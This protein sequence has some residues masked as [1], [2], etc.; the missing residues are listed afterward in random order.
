MSVRKPQIFVS[1]SQYDRDIRASFNTIFART[2]V[3]S[4]CIEFEKVSLPAWPKIKDAINA[5]ETVF[6]LLGPKIRKSIY[7]Q[8]WIAFEVGLSCALGK[9]VWV[10]EQM[11]SKIDFPIP[12]V[13]DYLLYSLD[14][15]IHFDY[16]KGI[17]EGY[18]ENVNSLHPKG[19]IPDGLLVEC[20]HCH[21]EF[22][23]HQTFGA[24]YCPSCRKPSWCK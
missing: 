24:Y 12:Y 21:L 2:N 11:G 4:V 18:G 9:R 22:S 7:T 19:K 5:S 20:R 1:H 14:D 23:M 15:N 17:I 13:T 3:K 6:L 16:V 8:N 10:F